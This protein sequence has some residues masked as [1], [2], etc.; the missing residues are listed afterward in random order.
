M[1]YLLDTNIV[2]VILKNNP[3]LNREY[4]ALRGQNAQIFISGITYYEV[5]RGL[6]YLNASRKLAK[7]EIFCAG[8][9]IIIPDLNILEIACRIHGN[10]K[11]RG[12]PIGDADILIAATAISHDFILVSHDADMLNIEGL[13]LENWVQ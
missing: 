6:L 8:V 7:F 10:L 1:G 9:T 2:S 5:K 3:T 13:N 4:R 11:A 12:R